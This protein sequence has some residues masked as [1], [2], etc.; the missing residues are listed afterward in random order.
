VNPFGDSPKR[1]DGVTT[2]IAALLIQDPENRAMALWCAIRV[3]LSRLTD[4]L[5]SKRPKFRDR[6]TRTQLQV[7]TEPEAKP[8]PSDGPATAWLLWTRDP[9]SSVVLW[10]AL[11]QKF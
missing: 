1:L 7:N 8:G 10:M 9:R 2:T 6:K 11:L 3:R 5:S 4:K